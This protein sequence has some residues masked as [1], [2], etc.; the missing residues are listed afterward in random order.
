MDGTFGKERGRQEIGFVC[1]DECLLQS[2]HLL[3]PASNWRDFCF[4]FVFRILL[5]NACTALI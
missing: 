3:M 2:R 4:R 1:L 5:L